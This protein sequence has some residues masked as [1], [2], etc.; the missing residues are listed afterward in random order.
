MNS[1]KNYND[2]SL[3]E[4]TILSWQDFLN[5]EH[6]WVKEPITSNFYFLCTRCGGAEGLRMPEGVL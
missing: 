3:D 4:D 6:D 5:C 1:P 2:L